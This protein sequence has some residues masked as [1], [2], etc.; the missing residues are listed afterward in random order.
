MAPVEQEIFIRIEEKQEQTGNKPQ[1]N[2]YE[3]RTGERIRHC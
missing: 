2:Y 1:C 3:L